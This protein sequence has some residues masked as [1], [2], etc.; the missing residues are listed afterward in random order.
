MVG[1]SRIYNKHSYK[2]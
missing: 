1:N 2:G